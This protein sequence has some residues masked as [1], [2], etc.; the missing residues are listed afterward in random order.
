V[1]SAVAAIV[2]AGLVVSTA[3][4]LPAFAPL[5][6]ASGPLLPR[7]RVRPNQRAD[8]A[9]VQRLLSFLDD[10]TEGRPAPIYVI[11]C[12]GTL[13]DQTLAFANRSLGTDYRAV[14]EILSSASID[15]QDGF[16]RGL[17]QAVYVVVPQPAQINMRPEDQQVVLL[18][19]QSFADGTDIARAFRRLPEE[20]LFEHGVRVWVFERARPHLASEVGE[21]SELLR[22][23]Y[24]DRPDIYQAR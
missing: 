9:E 20:F 16:P 19:T 7:N 4:F 21:F 6:D 2:V 8:L 24:P 1:A 14:G 23:R 11:G 10:R 12:S 3:V 5:A 13:S 17:L 22:E 15:R 18:P